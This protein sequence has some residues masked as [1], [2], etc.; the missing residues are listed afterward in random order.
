[1]ISETDSPNYY[2]K[3]KTITGIAFVI[4]FIMSLLNLLAQKNN[5]SR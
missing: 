4:V 5:L 2:L 1:M 3:Y